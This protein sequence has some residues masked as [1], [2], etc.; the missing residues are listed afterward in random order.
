MKGYL[1]TIL[2]GIAIILIAI[3]IHVNSI[4]TTCIGGAF[5]GFYNAMM[6]KQD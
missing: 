5:V 4:I 2:L 3:G 6:Y 1:T